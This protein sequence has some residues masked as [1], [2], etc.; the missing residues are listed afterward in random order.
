VSR[1]KEVSFTK[2]NKAEKLKQAMLGQKREG[3]DDPLTRY[4]AKEAMT[5]VKEHEQTVA[6]IQV[7]RKSESQ[8]K[9]EQIPKR[10]QKEPEEV[11]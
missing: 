4:R 10:Q 8:D 11:E 2:K 3:I 5:P 1:A 7:I 9:L 6:E